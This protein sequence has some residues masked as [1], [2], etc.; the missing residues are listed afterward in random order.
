[1][2]VLEVRDPFGIDALAFTTRPNL[3]PGPRVSGG[4]TPPSQPARTPAFL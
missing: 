3:V 4:E 2:R 1:M